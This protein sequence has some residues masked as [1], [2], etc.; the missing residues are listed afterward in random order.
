MSRH[1]WYQAWHDY[2]AWK[3]SP[4]T[5]ARP[6]PAAMMMCCIVMARRK[7]VK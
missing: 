1:D 6:Y 2:R 4:A 7:G 5:V 3:R